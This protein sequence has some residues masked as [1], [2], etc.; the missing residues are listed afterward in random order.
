MIASDGSG[1]R[2]ER[3]NGSETSRSAG[4]KDGKNVGGRVGGVR[5]RMAGDPITAPSDPPED[6]VAPAA[7]PC[8]PTPP[9]TSPTPA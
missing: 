1:I 6:Q 7:G 2:A 8:P 4:R 3:V 5:Y 9:H